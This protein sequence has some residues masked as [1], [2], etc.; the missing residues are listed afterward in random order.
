TIPGADATTYWWDNAFRPVAM[1]DGEG[2]IRVTTYDDYNRITHIHSKN[3]SISANPA[4]V[5]AEGSITGDQLLLENEYVAD[6]TWLEK[7]TETVITAGG[8]DG[9]KIT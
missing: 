6:H 4:D 8:F 7:T 2:N 1:Q 5:V 3:G 9:E